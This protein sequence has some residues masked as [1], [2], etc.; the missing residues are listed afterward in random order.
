VALAEEFP[1]A[2]AATE[3]ALRASLMR[4]Q[5]RDPHG[6]AAALLAPYRLTQDPRLLARVAG[7]FVRQCETL[8][9]PWP[10]TARETLRHVIRV[11]GPV[12]LRTA[13][14]ERS[15]KAWLRSLDDSPRRPLLGTVAGMSRDLP[16]RLVPVHGHA[17]PT[18]TSSALLYDGRELRLVESGDLEERWR[19]PLDDPA[20]LV[21]LRDEQRALVWL[22][23][24]RE[25]PRAVMIDAIDGSELWTTP[26]LRR[27]LGDGINELFV[28]AGARKQMPNSRPFEPKETLPLVAGERLFMV[29]RTGGTVAFD[30]DDG[31]DPTWAVERALDEVHVAA[32]SELGVVLAGASRRAE[33]EGQLTPRIVILA[34]DDGSVRHRITPP[35][36]GA[37]VRWLRIG[38]LATLIFGTAEG[39][40]AMDMLTGE[41]RWGNLS[42]EAVDTLNAWVGGDHIIVEDNASDIRALALADGTITDAFA[43]P[44]HGDWN[45]LD[46]QGVR[47]VDDRIYARYRQRV[48]RFDELGVVLGAD[49]ITDRRDYRWMLPTADG[50]LVVSRFKTEQAVIPNRM[51]RRMQHTYRIYHLSENCKVRQEH[52]LSDAITSQLT[53]AAVIDGWLL[54]S[55]SASNT[56]AIPMSTP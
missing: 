10:E 7:A 42:F 21:L 50:L 13:D 45:P 15:A 14:G 38:P 23:A 3:A 12:D 2:D 26:A 56:L 36:S 11:A 54:L 25:D 35:G 4:L 47:I 16:G 39:V 22:S 44:A 24:D 41:L 27:H 48:V 30:L 1:F 9:R 18:D 8:D 40:F 55:S 53:E 32:A 29:R 31:T 6:A 33:G 28:E 46:I 20:P 17:G 19:H 52:E 5:K 43:K 49:I 51:G 34:P 37:G